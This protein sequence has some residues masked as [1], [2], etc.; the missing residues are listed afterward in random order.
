MKLTQI[1]DL[2]RCSLDTIIANSA[3]RVMGE[4]AEGKMDLQFVRFGLACAKLN[5]L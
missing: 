3:L 5:R 1:F 2:L 4:K